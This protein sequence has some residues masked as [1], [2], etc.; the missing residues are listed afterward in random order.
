MFVISLWKSELASKD[1]SFRPKCTCMIHYRVTQRNPHPMCHYEADANEFGTITWACHGQC[2]DFTY[3]RIRADQERLIPV[4]DT[5]EAWG[6]DYLET[7]RNRVQQARRSLGG[8][9]ARLCYLK[10]SCFTLS[11][12]ELEESYSRKDST[13]VNT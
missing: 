1:I 8:K 12:Q 10:V 11:A 4:G 7:A 5:P 2:G 9:R 3:W 13:A 6:D